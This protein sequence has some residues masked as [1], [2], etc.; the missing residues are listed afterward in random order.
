M[1]IQLQFSEIVGCANL[2]QRFF[3]CVLC[4]LRFSCK[5]M[6]GSSFNVIYTDFRILVYN[7]IS[8]SNDFRAKMQMVFKKKENN[9]I[10]Y[11]SRV[12]KCKP[13]LILPGT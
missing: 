9:I 6:F 5:K 13:H 11:K 10:V 12:D 3:G 2:F 8:M 1:I 7:T 4:I